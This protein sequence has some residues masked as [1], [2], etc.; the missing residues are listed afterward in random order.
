MAQR[1]AIEAARGVG[2]PTKSPPL[3]GSAVAACSQRGKQ[4]RQR[5]TVSARTSRRFPKSFQS[6]PKPSSSNTNGHR[7]A[8]LLV[9]F[10]SPAPWTNHCKRAVITFVGGRNNSMSDQL[11][12]F[13]T[14]TSR[15]PFVVQNWCGAMPEPGHMHAAHPPMREPP[16]FHT[17][18]LLLHT[19]A[20]HW[21][22]I[23]R[24]SRSP[25]SINRLSL[26]TSVGCIRRTWWRAS[27][28]SGRDH[29][30]CRSRDTTPR[31][32]GMATH[33]SCLP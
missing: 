27:S 4:P 5:D 21:G 25:P 20:S 6:T 17:S 16:S 22:E 24:R 9:S 11:D 31:A 8:A 18:S 15:T 14:N 7:H 2:S 1:A 29:K 3:I 12:E 30:A 33:P 32:S 26:K 28:C 13:V 10:A 19:S 23:P